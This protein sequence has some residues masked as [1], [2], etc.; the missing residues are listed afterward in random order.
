MNNQNLFATSRFKHTATQ[1]RCSFGVIYRAQQTRFGPDVIHYFALIPHMVAGGNYIDAHGKQAF[2]NGC[3][4]P[5]T[6]GGIFCVNH[7]EI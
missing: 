4:N 1:P 2:T 5:K 7:N 6:V 3:G